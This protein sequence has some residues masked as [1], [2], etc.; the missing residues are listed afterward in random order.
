MMLLVLGLVG[1]GIGAMAAIAFLDPNDESSTPFTA[2]DVVD[3]RDLA[4]LTSPTPSPSPTPTATPGRGSGTSRQVAPAPSPTLDP[5]RDPRTPRIPRGGGVTTPPPDTPI[6][7]ELA[8]E[9][10]DC[11]DE[12]SEEAREQCRDEVEQEWEEDHP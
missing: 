3:A 1:G 7:D 9:L 12:G 11:D 6:P 4:N 10:A 2:G 8:E 5:N